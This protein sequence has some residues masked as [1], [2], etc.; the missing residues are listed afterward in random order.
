MI[1]NLLFRSIF[2]ILIIL[3]FL[4]PSYSEELKFIGVENPPFYFTSKGKI[5]GYSKAIIEAVCKKTQINC[6]FETGTFKTVIEKLDNGAVTGMVA[7]LPNPKSD[8][9]KMATLIKSPFVAL[10]IKNQKKKSILSDLS[11]YTF[12]IEQKWP[13]L[14]LLEEQKKLLPNIKILYESDT[15]MLL[16][17]LNNFEYGEKAATLISR[18]RFE[19]LSKTEKLQLNNI[20][21]ASGAITGK[22]GIIFSSKKVH[23][24]LVEKFTDDLKLI[25]KSPEFKNI[26][27]KFKMELS[28]DI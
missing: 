19:F 25:L 16:K 15:V 11:N 14:I 13:Y 7:L 18:A 5:I 9:R 8:A 2:G 12:V 24:A 4:T 3:L 1:P 26:L 22:Q 17:K 23:D 10:T 21:E 27:S 6:I 20:E 28:K